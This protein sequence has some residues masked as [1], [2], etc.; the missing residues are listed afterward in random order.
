MT[1]NDRIYEFLVEDEADLK[2]SFRMVFLICD[3]EAGRLV[4]EP[5]VGF[6][7]PPPP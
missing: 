2:I 1:K 4:N 7:V 5:V 6:K 3:R